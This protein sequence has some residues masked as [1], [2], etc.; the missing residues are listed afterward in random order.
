MKNNIEK[1]LTFTFLCVIII[2]DNKER[3]LKKISLE[4]NEK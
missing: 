4:N 1:N 2:T 3:F